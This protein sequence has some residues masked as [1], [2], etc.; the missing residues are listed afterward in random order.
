MG[1]TI[2]LWSGG[3]TRMFSGG[4]MGDKIFSL[5]QSGVDQKFF[6][7]SRGGT[8]IFFQEGGGRILCKGGVLLLYRGGTNIFPHMQWGDQYFFS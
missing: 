6:R 4:L 1:R 5:G 3:G 8:R 7:G 2:R